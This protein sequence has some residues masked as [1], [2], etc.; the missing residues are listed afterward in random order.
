MTPKSL[1]EINWPLRD[2][3]TSFK[4]VWKLA[5]CTGKHEHFWREIM[6]SCKNVRRSWL[7]I[8]KILY[9]CKIGYANSFQGFHHSI[10]QQIL[11]TIR[12]VTGAVRAPKPGKTPIMA[13]CR[14]CRR[15]LLFFKIEGRPRSCRSYHIWR[16]WFNAI[17][18]IFILHFLD[19]KTFK[20]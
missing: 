14:H 4:V 19:S 16:P 9:L 2:H 6:N 5:D 20:G 17:H 1:F 3:F 15:R 13:A 12:G 18:H 8:H 10:F 7:Y 11:L